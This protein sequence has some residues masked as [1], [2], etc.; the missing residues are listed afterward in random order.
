MPIINWTTNAD[1]NGTSFRSYFY[2]GGEV[3]A[4]AEIVAKLIT[5]SKQ[6]PTAA[7]DGEKVSVEFTGT[8]KSVAFTLYDYKGDFQLHI[9]GQPGLDVL[10]LQI[11]LDKL[12]IEGV[13]PTPFTARTAYDEEVKYGWP[14][15]A[16]HLTVAA[17]GLVSKWDHEDMA[18]RAARGNERYVRLVLTPEQ[19]QELQNAARNIE[20]TVR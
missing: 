14:T 19:L 10:G 7:S 15:V 9:G 13:T 6:D 5:L 1:I 20:A 3:E 8:F 4:F 18:R 17:D 12:L 2:E 16:F 11:A